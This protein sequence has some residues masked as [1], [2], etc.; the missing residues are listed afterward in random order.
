MG[1]G[2]WRLE[3]S[4]TFA[5]SLPAP[6]FHI[7]LCAVS[8]SVYM[9]FIIYLSIRAYNVYSRY[10]WC[11]AP[12]WHLPHTTQLLVSSCQH[13]QLFP[14]RLSSET[15]TCLWE[16]LE[17]IGINIHLP[18]QQPSTKAAIGDQMLPTPLPFGE[19]GQLWGMFSTVSSKT[20]LPQGDLHIGCVSLA[21][22]FPT[23]LLVLRDHLPTHKLLSNPP[24][25]ACFWRNPT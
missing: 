8:V 14:W 23:A 16:T 12:S 4:C 3:D 6:C 1:V 9:Y 19:W 21:A 18:P 24:L 17:I 11:P 15:E 13:L 2:E 22:S 20:K 5:L 25:R 10:Y 7:L